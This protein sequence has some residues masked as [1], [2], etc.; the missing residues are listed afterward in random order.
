[1]KRILYLSLLTL[2]PAFL[3]AEENLSS[4]QGQWVS[5]R[6][7]TVIS[8]DFYN[9]YLLVNGLNRNSRRKYAY[10][11]RNTYRNRSGDIIRVNGRRQIVFNGANC[12][13]NLVFTRYKRN[14]NLR[15][16]NYNNDYNYDSYSRDNNNRRDIDYLSGEYFA[17]E[18]D[19]YISI[20]R[21]AEGLR[22]RIGNG[23]WVSFRQ[24]ATNSDQ[25][26][27][28]RGNTYRLRN[29]GSLRYVS[30]DREIIINLSKR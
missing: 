23:K 21:T 29:D 13:R 9:G 12:G 18:I 2:L 30:Y 4:I 3:M 14:N 6:G 22:A 8:I 20:N 24:S 1:M 25:Y 26:V 16:N 11:N 28:H 5:T 10:H 17:R 19:Q 15:G 27:D 7:N